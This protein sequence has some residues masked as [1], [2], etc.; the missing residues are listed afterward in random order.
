[1]GAPTTVVLGHE[2]DVGI[3]GQTF[4]VTKGAVTLRAREQECGD[5]AS[6]K[7]EMHKGGREV[8]EVNLDFYLKTD[9]ILH[10]APLGIKQGDYIDLAVFAKGDGVQDPYASDYFEVYEFRCD[11][12]I[13]GKVSGH[14]AGKSSGEFTQPAD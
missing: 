4:G 5:T 12:D 7:Y 14:I 1:M 3:N 6:G 10:S 8:M 11:I 13:D 2:A 9:E